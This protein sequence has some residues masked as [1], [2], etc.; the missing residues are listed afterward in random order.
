M[1]L[2]EY[3]TYVIL[4][5]I[6]VAVTAAPVLYINLDFLYRDSYYV[7][8]FWLHITLSISND[9]WFASTPQRLQPFQ[10]LNSLE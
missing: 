4:P 6:A 7:I 8:G 9:Y 10:N 2:H 1:E 3:A 5:L